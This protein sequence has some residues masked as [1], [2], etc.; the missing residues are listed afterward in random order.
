MTNYKTQFNL[1]VNAINHYNALV[2]QP[3]P[4]VWGKMTEEEIEDGFNNINNP[5]HDDWGTKSFNI[6]HFIECVEFE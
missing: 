3:C 4:M 5:L 2:L 1:V 6:L